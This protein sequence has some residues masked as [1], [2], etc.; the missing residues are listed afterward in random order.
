MDDIIKQLETSMELASPARRVQRVRHELRIRDVHVVRTERPAPGFARI[1]F[2]GE[3][4][5]GFTSLGFDDHVKLMLTAPDG[6]PQRRDYTP[7]HFDAQARELTV[8]FALHG[9]GPATRWAEAARPGDAAVIGGPRGSMIVPADHDWHLLA[10][11][12]SAAPAIARRLAQLP[13]GAHA[14]VVARLD[15]AAILSLPDS[16]ARVQLQRVPDDDA[17]VAALGALPLPAGDGYA[18]AAGEAATMARVREL[19]RAKGHPLAAMRV[20]AYWKHGAA[21]FHEETAG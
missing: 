15:D 7:R 18:W 13:E 8:D 20:A 14:I 5:Q 9:H 11:D 12:A 10:G 3:A 4:L 1:V 17:L 2:G 21:A 6:S 19:L 16:R